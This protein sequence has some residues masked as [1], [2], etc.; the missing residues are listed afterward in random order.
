METTALLDCPDDG[1]FVQ[2]RRRRKRISEPAKTTPAKRNTPAPTPAID[3]ETRYGTSI[4]TKLREAFSLQQRGL[5]LDE[6]CDT[7][8]LPRRYR[9]EVEPV[10]NPEW[11]PL[12]TEI[13]RDSGMIRRGELV[14]DERQEKIRREWREALAR[15]ESE[16]SSLLWELSGRIPEDDAWPPPPWL[17]SAGMVEC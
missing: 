4:A 10:A 9:G 3:A 13:E 2:V 8:C 17:Y 15:G 6:A 5:S 11:V 7:V 1:T 16:R 12:P 14:I